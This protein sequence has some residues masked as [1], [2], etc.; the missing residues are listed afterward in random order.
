MCFGK[1]WFGAFLPKL[2]M[3]HEPAWGFI[4]L[5]W[6]QQYNRSWPKRHLYASWVHFYIVLLRQGDGS[7]L[8]RDFTSAL[9]SHNR[10]M[11]DDWSTST[12]HKPQILR[13]LIKLKSSYWFGLGF[14]VHVTPNQHELQFFWFVPTTPRLHIN[15]I[16]HI[17]KT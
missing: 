13:W 14:V 7:R 4:L 17:Y 10:E 16:W 9:H 15:T 3:K 1:S 2:A 8:W 5:W 11:R 6:W 12:E